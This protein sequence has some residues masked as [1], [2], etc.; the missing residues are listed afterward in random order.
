VP[1]R[2]GAA[3]ERDELGER[4][5]AHTYDRDHGHTNTQIDKKLEDRVGTVTRALRR[6]VK[7]NLKRL[8]NDTKKTTTYV[9]SD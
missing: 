6:D 2:P 3:G 8:L 7:A 1:G 9:E 4:D 5:H